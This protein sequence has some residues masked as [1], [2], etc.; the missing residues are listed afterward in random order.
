MNKFIEAGT[1]GFAKVGVAA[2]V[3]GA[4]VGGYAVDE[5]WMGVV[6]SNAEKLPHGL[7]GKPSNNK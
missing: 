2:T 3:A 5:V 4:I 6:P 7:I 1:H